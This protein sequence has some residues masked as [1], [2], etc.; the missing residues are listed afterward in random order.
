MNKVVLMGR[1]TR[2]PEVRYSQSD[3]SMAIARFS[4]AV[5]R[6]RGRNS[7]DGQQTAD[8][9]NC[10]AFGKLGEFVEKYLHKGTKV[11]LSGR[12]QTGS[13]TNKDGVKVYTTDIVAE[14]LEFAESKSAQAG[15]QDYS[16][17]P[18]RTSAP[19]PSAAPSSQ[20]QSSLRKRIRR[21]SWLSIEMMAISPSDAREISTEREKFA[22]SAERTA[23]LTT[24]TQLHCVSTSPREERSFPE[25]LQAHALHI[26][27]LLP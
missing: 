12:I 15:S 14:D 11:V 24:R 16:A 2:D 27:E 26:R 5:D 1:L 19:A 10:V 7:G 17:A 8:F 13:Y 6:R 9:L 22:Y 21:K 25:E 3:N 4:L 18:A 20:P 23:Q